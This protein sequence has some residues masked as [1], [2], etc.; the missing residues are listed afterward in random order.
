MTSKTNDTNYMC[1]I[2]ARIESS[3]NFKNGRAQN[4]GQ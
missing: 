3:P 2:K 4:R 1:H